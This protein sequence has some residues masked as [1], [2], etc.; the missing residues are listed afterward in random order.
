MAVLKIVENFVDTYRIHKQNRRPVEPNGFTKVSLGCSQAVRHRV[1]IS[2]FLGSIPSTP[3]I[4]HF[5]LSIFS[6]NFVLNHLNP[7]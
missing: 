6:K 4:R 5:T 3:A 1:L 7:I 2:A